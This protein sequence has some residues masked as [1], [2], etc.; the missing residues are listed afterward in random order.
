MA[1]NQQNINQIEL[2]LKNREKSG[3]FY[4][5]VYIIELTNKC[6]LKCKICPNN[7]IDYSQ[8]G[9]ID[10]KLFEKIIIDISPYCEFLMLYWMG[11][12]L[13]HK[14][15]NQLLEVA[16]V[17]I[18][19]KI[20]VSSNMTIN[21]PSFYES[22][23]RNSDFFLC[24]VDRWDKLAYED[25]RQGSSFEDV[26]RN[27][28]ELL[29]KKK[30]NH[31]CEVIVKAL[32]I[33]ISS[34]EFDCFKKY[35][36][37]LGAKTLLAWV[38]DWAGTLPTLRKNSQL[39]IP[40]Q[41]NTRVPCADLWFKMPINWRGDVLMCCFD[42]SYSHKIGSVEN[43]SDWLKTIWHSDLIKKIRENQLSGKWRNNT[44]CEKCTTWAEL[45]EH[46]AYVNC[47]EK[48]YFTVF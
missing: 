24:C 2:S 35:W 42:W 8:K 20:A 45:F 7:Q 34:T 44:L 4:P 21:N 12:P 22:A 14:K 13:L 48:S 15:F 27:I 41:Q 17:N 36:E 38:S 3:P 18:R 25:L 16:R 31:N 37:R 32:D 23:L 11:E 19:G 39:D 26:V 40:H 6:N 10:E 30:S 43:S 47:N 46:D 5:S 33:S 29:K 9:Y 1:V 28:E